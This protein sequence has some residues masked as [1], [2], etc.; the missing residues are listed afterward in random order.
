MGEGGGRRGGLHGHPTRR[1]GRRGGEKWRALL[2][3]ALPSPSQV[4]FSGD[5]AGLTWSNLAYQPYFSATAVNVGHGF[6][7][8]DIEGPA[9]DME[10]YTRWIQVGG[11][12]Q[13]CRG[14]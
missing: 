10:M 11:G 13:A 7:T 12:G 8:H 14:R 3:A 4:G 2:S 1:R 5:V 6:W 9:D